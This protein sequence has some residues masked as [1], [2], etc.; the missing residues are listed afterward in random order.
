MSM[1][2]RKISQWWLAGLAAMF[3]A[4]VL[5]P[6]SALALAAR[7]RGDGVRDGCGRAIG[8]RQPH[9]GELSSS[10]RRA[11]RLFVTSN[12]I[13]T[14]TVGHECGGEVTTVLVR[15][16]LADGRV[17]MQRR[18]RA[19]WRASCRAASRRYYDKVQAAAGRVPQRRTT[20]RWCR[21]VLAPVPW[22][23]RPCLYCSSEC[24]AAWARDGRSGRRG[25]GHVAAEPF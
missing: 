2:R 20:C 19:C 6:S 25:S 10:Q 12:E 22:P 9:P 7:Q 21:L 24:R 17:R 5:I 18:C 3:P 14:C 4:G 16:A 23:G 13:W 8:A 11:E 15:R 1:A